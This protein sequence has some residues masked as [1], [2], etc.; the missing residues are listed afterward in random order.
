MSTQGYTIIWETFLWMKGNNLCSK[1]RACQVLII[2][3]FAFT[4]TDFPFN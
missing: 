1:Y 2:L 3:L 4:K